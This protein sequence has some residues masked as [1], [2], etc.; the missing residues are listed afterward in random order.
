M[1]LEEERRRGAA[2]QNREHYNKTYI[3][4]LFRK[5]GLQKSKKKSMFEMQL[6]EHAYNI[7]LK[8]TSQSH[9]LSS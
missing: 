6:G 8:Y 7:T 3:I 5:E 1:I 9:D 4:I 2:E